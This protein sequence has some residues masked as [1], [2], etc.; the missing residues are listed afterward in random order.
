MFHAAS[1]VSASRQK[2]ACGRP[3]F[4]AMRAAP[5]PTITAH[6]SGSQTYFLPCRLPFTKHAS[7]CSNGSALLR[8]HLASPE[9]C[10]E[11]VSL[12]QV[13]VDACFGH[14]PFL[15]NDDSVGA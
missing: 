13:G 5:V 6:A 9:R 15:Q 10:I 1:A 3:P 8:V 14:A 4:A 7:A 11:S 2:Q 12:Q